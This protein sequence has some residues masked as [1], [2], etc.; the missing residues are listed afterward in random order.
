[1][2]SLDSYRHASGLPSQRMNAQLLTGPFGAGRWAGWEQFMRMKAYLAL[3]ILFM[4]LLTGCNRSVLQSALIVQPGKQFE[5][6]GNQ[7]GAFTIKARNVGDVAVELSE[8]RADGQ[9]V[10][11]GRFAPGDRQ[12]I[13]F[14]A[15]SAALVDNSTAKAAQLNL[16][17]TGDKNLSMRERTPRPF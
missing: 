4:A 9:T 8:R 10:A 15:G 6:G 5:L 17:V 14:A 7:Q 2:K 3:G 1:M 16:T 11:L 12:T 13:R